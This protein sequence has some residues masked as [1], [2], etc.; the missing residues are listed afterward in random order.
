MNSANFEVGSDDSLVYGFSPILA[1]KNPNL[2]TWL[3]LGT[4]NMKPRPAL[5]LAT[6][7]RQSDTFDILARSGKKFIAQLG[8]P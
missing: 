1:R 8:K 6:E 5:A 2:A 7:E 3:E 4:K